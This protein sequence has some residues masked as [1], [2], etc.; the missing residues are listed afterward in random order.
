MIRMVVMR[1]GHHVANGY[2]RGLTLSAEKGAGVQACHGDLTLP[3]L[4][5]RFANGSYL[6][7]R[8]YCL[9]YPPLYP[10][11]STRALCECASA[12]MVRSCPIP[13]ARSRPQ[14]KLVIIHAA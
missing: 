12:S 9:Q 14:A 3:P 8:S 6:P 11:N 2:K 13:Y 5:R 4:I 7:L 1:P 10:F